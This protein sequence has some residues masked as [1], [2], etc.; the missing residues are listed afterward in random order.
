[1]NV[2][3]VKNLTDYLDIDKSFFGAL[4]LGLFYLKI[5]FVEN[6]FIF[7]INIFII[8]AIIIT[9]LSIILG[10]CSIKKFK[11]DYRQY[12]IFGI[13]IFVFP[14]VSSLIK[15]DILSKI[16][17][18]LLGISLFYLLSTFFND[19]ILE[20]RRSQKLN[21]ISNVKKEI[22]IECSDRVT[23]IEE[24]LLPKISKY[25]D[26]E[27]IKEKLKKID[28]ILMKIS[29]KLND[30]TML[31]ES[32]CVEGNLEKLPD[33]KE[34]KR[35]LKELKLKLIEVKKEVKK[36]S[37]KT[38]NN[39][40]KTLK[41]MEVNLNESQE[42]IEKVQIKDPIEL[43]PFKIAFLIIGIILS[44]V[45]IIYYYDHEIKFNRFNEIHSGIYLLFS[46][47]LLNSWIN[48]NEK[49]EE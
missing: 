16:N 6:I 49:I 39:I 14:A 34:V 19:V 46:L 2:A 8:I 35:N 31:K 27:K 33:M 23:E 29:E 3:S 17:D 24:E 43:Y 44:I 15:N 32:V 47:L 48:E 4:S 40:K 38:E 37:V 9:I 36:E 45:L 1:M 7:K 20:K 30:L 42:I 10:Y 5:S 41:K 26:I 28:K 11:E 12:V 22:L 13:M 25:L 18:V 21:K